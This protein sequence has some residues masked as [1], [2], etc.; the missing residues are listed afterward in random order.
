MNGRNE[1][2]R[3]V[4]KKSIASLQFKSDNRKIRSSVK[5]AKYFEN[6]NEFK[7]NGK[8]T[9]T[10]FTFLIKGQGASALKQKRAGRVGTKTKKGRAPRP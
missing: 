4:A 3:C 7:V 5:T 10:I 6:V 9:K 1:S 8:S 2:D